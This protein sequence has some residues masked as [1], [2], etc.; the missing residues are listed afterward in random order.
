MVNVADV[1]KEQDNGCQDHER[2]EGGV[3]QCAVVCARLFAVA[4]I[5]S[6]CGVACEY[7]SLRDEASNE[8]AVGSE[9]EDRV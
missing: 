9:E 3:V 2:E 4:C 8:C 1:S 6:G 7:V 5:F